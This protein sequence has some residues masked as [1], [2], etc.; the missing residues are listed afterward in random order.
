MILYLLLVPLII[1]FPFWIHVTLKPNPI[2]SLVSGVLLMIMIAV[3]CW[4]GGR[5]SGIINSNVHFRNGVKNLVN[6][7]ILLLENNED[8]ELLK[9]MKSFKENYSPDYLTYSNYMNDKV[10]EVFPTEEKSTTIGK[11]N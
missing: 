2:K 1:L 7:S 5:D 4:A 9:K 11:D 3:G 6:S 8:K 10:K